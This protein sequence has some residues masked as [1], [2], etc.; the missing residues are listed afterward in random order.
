VTVYKKD[1]LSYLTNDAKL[2]ANQTSRKLAS[3][4]MNQ[5]QLNNKERQDLMPASDKDRTRGKFLHLD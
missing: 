5:Y 1:S 2:K 4:V 3:L